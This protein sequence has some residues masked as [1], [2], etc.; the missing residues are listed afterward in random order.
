[1]TDILDELLKHCTSIT[2]TR[3]N[4]N[5]P[6]SEIICEVDCSVKDSEGRFQ[7]GKFRPSGKTAKEALHRVKIYVDAFVAAAGGE[8]I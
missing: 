7:Y 1:M 5:L 8:R 4:P 6:D 3:H 2:L